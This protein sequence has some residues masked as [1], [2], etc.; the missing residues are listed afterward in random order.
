MK[1]EQFM[2]ITDKWSDNDMV[3]FLMQ[4]PVWNEM[5]KRFVMHNWRDIVNIKDIAEFS[6]LHNIVLYTNLEGEE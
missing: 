3:L 1:Y 6:Q 2:K 4:F 5:I